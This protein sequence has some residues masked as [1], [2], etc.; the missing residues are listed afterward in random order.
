MILTAPTAAIAVGRFGLTANTQTFKS[1]LT[2]STRTVELP[3]ARWQGTLELSPRLRDED[4]G[5]EWRAFFAEA[6][7]QSGRFYQG[8]PDYRGPRGSGTGSPTVT[9]SNQVGRALITHGW[10]NGEIVLRPADFVSW[11]TPSGWRELHMVTRDVLS[12]GSGAATIDLSPPIRESPALEAALILND[13]TFVAMMTTSEEGMYNV[14]PGGVYV[15][16]FSF[17]EAFTE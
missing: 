5:A 10:A 2:G 14:T 11:D 17:I 13:P 7:G 3:G 12:N 15:S 9:Y 4:E 16:S 6:L 1:P 8:P